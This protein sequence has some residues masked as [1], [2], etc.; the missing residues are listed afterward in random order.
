M[1]LVSD[2]FTSLP[3]IR[4]PESVVKIGLAKNT[5]GSPYIAALI[6]D[7]ENIMY[8]CTKIKINVECSAITADVYLLE[9]QSNGEPMCFPDKPRTFI[10]EASVEF[11]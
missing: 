5:D 7:G 11:V 4:K 2:T 9:V 1:L 8:R 6:L 3:S 10:V